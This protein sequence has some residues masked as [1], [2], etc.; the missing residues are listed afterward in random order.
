MYLR[1][2]FVLLS[3]LSVVLVA[4]CAGS[5]EAKDKEDREPFIIDTEPETPGGLRLAPTDSSI[6]TIQLYRSILGGRNEFEVDAEIEAQF[7]VIALRSSDVLNLEFDLMEP[8]GRPLSVYFYHADRNWS[9]DLS[10]A[11]YLGSFQR[12]DIL[13]YTPSRATDIGYTHYTYRFPSESISFLLSGNYVVRVTEQGREEDVLFERPFYIT[14]QLT[15]VQLSVENVLIGQSGFSSIQPAALFLPPPGLDNNVF[16]YTVCFVRNGRFEAYRCTDQ[17]RLT[18]PPAIRFYLD[19]S[20]AYE[21]VTANYFLDLSTLRVGNQISRIDFTEA[22][23]DVILE[24][25]YARFPGDPLDPILNGQTIVS[26]AVTDVANPDLSAQYV[27]VSFGYV[28]DSGRPVSGEVYLVGSFNGWEVNSDY[29][30]NWVPENNQYELEVLLKQG[31][32][33]YRY[34][35]NNDQLPR[36]TAPSI[37]NLYT[38]FVYFSDIRENTDRLLAVNSFR[39]Q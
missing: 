23:Y 16:D 30:L 10:P 17:V 27:N 24:P 38:A 39:G 32:Y 22:P 5:K 21:P 12:G 9:R 37:N 14:E 18:Q 11:E 4:G 34:L 13:S 8:N 28:P 15:S 36:G 2:A 7:P 26:G 35:L 29:A 20:Q 25:D 3:T 31:Q 33:D 6:R 19:T 1:E